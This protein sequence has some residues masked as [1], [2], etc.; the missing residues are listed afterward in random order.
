[1]PIGCVRFFDATKGY[2]FI[3]PDAGG[4]DVFVDKAAIRQAGILEFEKGQ[5]VTFE[6]EQDS[7]GASKA[8]KLE[9]VGTTKTQRVHP[10]NNSDRHVRSTLAKGAAPGKSIAATHTFQLNYERY[11]ELAQNTLDDRVAR[12][13]YLQHAEH[14][15]RMM[16]GPAS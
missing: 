16:N 15:Y 14:Y 4:N 7:K 10:I 1:M 6:I 12:E 9:S 13:G 5:S 2:G 3:I 11:V 8:V